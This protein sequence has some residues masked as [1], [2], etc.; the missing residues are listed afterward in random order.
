MRYRFLL[1]FF[2][3]PWTVHSESLAE[4]VQSAYRKTETFRANF[5]QKTH[6]AALDRDVEEKGELVFSRPGKFSI[7]YQGDRERHYISDGKTLWIYRPQDKEVEIYEKLNDM[8]SREAL[9]FLGGLGEMNK[10][11]VVSLPGAEL[12]RLVP[13]S[14]SSP[15]KEIQMTVDPV[16]SLAASVRLFPKS[17]NQSHYRF[18]D[19]RTNEKVS[20]KT[21]QFHERG[22]R[23]TRPLQL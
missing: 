12:L 6:I 19:V 4:K 21:F 18:T 7:H 13:R 5:I 11:F 22:V 15:F 9:A 20:D 10:E 8:V 1:F 16:T 23:E 3:V 17:G 2:L 14:A